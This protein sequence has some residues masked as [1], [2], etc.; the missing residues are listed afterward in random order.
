MSDKKKR[1]FGLAAQLTQPRSVPTAA[2]T[3]QPA[4]LPTR[5]VGL[6]DNS[7]DPIPRAEP[8]YSQPRY[9][10][11]SPP[12]NEKK[13]PGAPQRAGGYVRRTITLDP[14]VSDYIDTAWRT[15]RDGNGRLVKGVSGFVESLIS[16]YRRQSRNGG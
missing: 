8:A 10:G 1:D 2:E 5:T 12:R 15:H 16:E 6:T 3:P 11:P 7:D 4:P 14:A 13:K 9:R